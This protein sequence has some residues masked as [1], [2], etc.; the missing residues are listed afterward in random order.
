MFH[1][2]LTLILA[3][4]VQAQASGI[5]AYTQAPDGAP[6]WPVQDICTVLADGS[7]DRCLTTDGHS[8]HPSWSP[9]GRRILFVHDSTLSEKP[10]YRE[11]ADTR[12]HHPVELSV[13]DADGG[14]RRVLRVIEPVIHG[15]AW[16]P[17]GNT[18][19]IAA[20]TA[21]K[22]GESPRRGLFLLPA[23]GR[24]ELRLFREDAMTPSWSP[25]G[26]R[27]AFAV[28][29]PR[30]RWRVHIANVDGTGEAALGNAKVNSGSPAWSPDGRK[31]AFAQFAEGG[32][33]EHVVV[34]NADGSDARQL[35]ADPAWSCSRPSWSP[36]GSHLLVSCRSAGSP[37]GMGVFSTGHPMP[38]CTRRV[39]LVPVVPGAQP[40]T[41]VD[42]DAAMAS[43]TNPR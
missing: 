26:T 41:L 15:A 6:P 5:I 27:L 43:F 13:M 10:P 29:H 39:F 18:L 30:G 19:A 9:D 24:G 20:T 21:V 42:H 2:V 37:C 23:S 16:S 1:R 7:G 32:V 31:I 11:T 8:H 22:P 17:D 3:G 25:D 36:G 12:S 33:R 40:R 34:T 35:T 38:E 28:E 14:N 4:C